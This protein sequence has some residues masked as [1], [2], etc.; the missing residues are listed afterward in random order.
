MSSGS[1]LGKLKNILVERSFFG[2]RSLLAF[3]FFLQHRG[4][5]APDILNWGLHL[6]DCLII[7][8]VENCRFER[9]VSPE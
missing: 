7:L 6:T 3:W 1:F 2:G 8:P 4:Q 5:Y 9:V